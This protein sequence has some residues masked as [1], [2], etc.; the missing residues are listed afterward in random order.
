MA[1]DALL[2]APKVPQ[3]PG[4]PCIQWF[5]CRSSGGSA[6]ARG[7]RCASQRNFSGLLLLAL[8]ILITKKVAG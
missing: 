6:V 8:P 5:C 4:R 1:R 3:V 7:S 2:R